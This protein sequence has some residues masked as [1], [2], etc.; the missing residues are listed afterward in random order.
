MNLKTIFARQFQFWWCSE[1]WQDKQEHAKNTLL[2]FASSYKPLLAPAKEIRNQ[3]ECKGMDFYFASI[4]SSTY[5]IHTWTAYRKKLAVGRQTMVEK[6]YTFPQIPM[7]PIMRTVIWKISALLHAA[8]F[9]A[10]TMT[11]WGKK[12]HTH[13]HVRRADVLEGHD[14]K[15]RNKVWKKDGR[16]CRVVAKALVV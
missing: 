4:A 5:M 16:L 11:W 2:A 13:A 15:P 3:N 10:A 12:K 14:A 8:P 1:N 7:F 6:I 9:S